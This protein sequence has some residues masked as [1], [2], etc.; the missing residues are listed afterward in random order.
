MNAVAVVAVACSFFC[1]IAA[2]RTEN[3]FQHEVVEVRLVYLVDTKILSTPALCMTLL[4]TALR[5][6]LLA[7]SIAR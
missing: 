3:A 6:A 5:Q 7:L 1:E 4:S 2:Q